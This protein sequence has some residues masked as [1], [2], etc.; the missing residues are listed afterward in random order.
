MGPWL[1]VDPDAQL[2]V[3]EGPRPIAQLLGELDL[4]DQEAVRLSARTLIHPAESPAK[5][6]ADPESKG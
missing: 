3:T 5:S 1:A 4:A 2:T 6:P